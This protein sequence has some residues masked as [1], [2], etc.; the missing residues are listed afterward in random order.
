MSFEDNK[1]FVLPGMVTRVFEIRAR[2]RCPW[3]EYTCYN[4]V[5]GTRVFEIRARKGC[6]WNEGTCLNAAGYGHLECLKYAH[7][8]GCPWDSRTCSSAAE[9]VTSSAEMHENGCPWDEYTC[10]NAVGEGHLSV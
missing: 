5:G 4:A 10:Y 1:F 2:K 3:D 9:H 7:E 6:P 8:K